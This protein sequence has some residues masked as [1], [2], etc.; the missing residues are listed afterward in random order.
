MNEI[1]IV[2][3]INQNHKRLVIDNVYGRIIV[4]YIQNNEK[5]FVILFFLNIF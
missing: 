4:K 3:I 2:I 5:L 1:N